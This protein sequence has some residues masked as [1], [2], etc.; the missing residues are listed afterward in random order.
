MSLPTQTKQWKLAHQP[1]QHIELSSEGSEP[2]TFKL[3]TTDIPSPLPSSTLLLKTLY[4]SNDPAQRTWITKYEQPERLYLPPVEPGQVMRARAVAEVLEVADGDDFNKGDLVLAS[5]GWTEYAVL[6]AK[7]CRPLQK[8]PT[9]I[10][11]G[12]SVFLGALGTTGL[13]AY[14]GFIEIAEAKAEDIV[15]VSGAAGATGSMVVQLAKNMLGCKKVIGIAGG[16]DKC[17]WVESLGADKCLDYKSSEF[18]EEL[19]QAT[20]D[21]V[22]VYFDN[23]GGQ[24]LDLL[25]SRMKRHGRIAVCGSISG[26]NSTE[27][28]TLSNWFEVITNRIQVRGFIVLDYMHKAQ[29]AIG[30]II[31]A[32]AQG[33]INI[34]DDME[35]VV[36]TEFD[37]V[38]KVFTKLF[39]G[40]NRGKLVTKLV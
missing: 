17:R 8:L 20:K 26:Y 35:T 10:K 27:P 5:T 14:Y 12:P 38:P 11:S 36:E 3:V 30:K 18:A 1:K 7:E 29:E 16:S 31:E 28:T 34:A 21:G 19:K 33:K 32:A 39:E 4:L 40:G 6:P 15:V 24:I 13:T 9:Q 22:D 25:L 37:G 23:V 2:Q